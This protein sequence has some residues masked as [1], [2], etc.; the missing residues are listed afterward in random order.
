MSIG[1]NPEVDFAA[2]SFAEQD[3]GSPWII[4]GQMIADK[5]ADGEK[6]LRNPSSHLA[7]KFHAAAVKPPKMGGGPV[8]PDELKGL[9]T[10]ALFSLIVGARIPYS[11]TGPIDFAQLG[12]EIFLVDK[13]GPVVR[14]CAWPA[15]L[16]LSRIGPDRLPDLTRYLP[17]PEDPTYPEQCL[18]LQLLLDHC[19][20]LL[21]RGVDERWTYGYFSAASQQLGRAWLALPPALRPDAW[22]RWNDKVALDYWIAVRFWFGTPFVHAQSGELQEIALRFTDETRTVVEREVGVLD[23]Y[24]AKREEILA[25][26]YGFPRLYRAGPPQGNDVTRESWT[27]WM[28][29]LMDVHKP[30]VDRFS[31]YPYLNAILGV[32]SSPEEEEWIDRVDHFGETSPDVARRIEEDVKLGRWRPLGEDSL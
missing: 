13:F 28:G 5:R 14:D 21:F 29:M 8:T 2:E 16:A 23:P 12:R 11:K 17:P 10:P 4:L 3:S 27:F 24:R 26:L 15:L 7:S 1:V 6:K 30:I 19:P 31:R 25:D 9:L 20:R 32:V 18:G 22:G